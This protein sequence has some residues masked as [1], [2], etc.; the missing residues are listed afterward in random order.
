MTVDTLRKLSKLFALL[1]AAVLAVLVLVSAFVLHN[2]YQSQQRYQ[3]NAEDTSRNLAIS[4]ENFLHSHFQEVDLAMRRAAS[5]FRTLHSERRFD[6]ATFSAFL[7]GL[8]ERLPQA[9]AVRGSDRDGRVI[10]GEKIDLA[11]P[12][13]LSI[14][15]FYQRSKTERELVFGVP[16]KSRISGEWVFP[17]MYALTL[18]DGGFGGTAYVNLNNSRITELFSSLNVGE[19]GVIILIDQQRRVLHRYP[20]S[21]AMQTGSQV[22]LSAETGGILASGQ[23]RA[24][25]SAVSVRD[26]R[27]RVVSVERI[28]GYPIFV[29][30]GLANQDFLTPWRK[31]ARDDAIFLAALYV[32]AGGLLLGVRAALRRQGQALQQ[33]LQKDQAL[34]G[35]LAALTQSEQRWRSLTE[36]LPQMVWTL[37]PQ[38]RFEFLSHHWQDF[39]GIDTVTLLAGA[40]WFDILHADDRGRI[41][42][43]WAA[44][45]AAGGEF[46]CD[47]RLR[48]ADGAWRVFDHHA[49]PQRDP[50]GRLL[51]WVGSSTDITAAREA[52]V[53]LSQAKDAALAAGRAKSEFVANMSHEIR[54]PM[55]AVLGMLQLLQQTAL[56]PRQQD[57]AV[58]AEAAAR[59][60]LSLLNDI[61]DFSKVEAGKLTLDCHPFSVDKLLRDL[62]VILSA[63]IG[64]KDVEVLFQIDPAL[65]KWV[66]GDALRLQ[67]IL[68][69]LSGNAIKFTAHGEV[70]LSVRLLARDEAGLRLAFSIRDTGIGISAEQCERIFEGFSQAEASTARR[71][72]GSGLGLAISQRLVRLMGGELSV[73]STPGLGSVFEF[74]VVLQPAAT[75]AALL[76][77]PTLLQQLDCLVVDDNP[78]ARQVLA[79][80]A[81]SFGWLVETAA[82][83]AAALAALARRGPARPYDVIFVDWRMPQL[84]GWDTAV[85]LRQMLPAGAG[86]LIIMVTAYDRE[87]LAQKQHDQPVQH[88][89]AGATLDGVLVKPVTAS[90]LFDA[91]ADAKLGQRRSAP[92]ATAAAQ[93][94]PSRRRLDGLR[95]L[96]VEDNPANQQVAREL[97]GY[98]GAEVALANCGQ[99]AIDAVRDGAPPDLIL[100]DIQMPDMDGYHATRAIRALLGWRTPPIVAMTAN[101]LASDRAAALAAGMVDHVGKPFDLDQLVA[102]ILAHGPDGAGGGDASGAGGSD[103]AGGPAAPRE[104]AVLNGGAAL[105]RMGGLSQLYLLALRDFAGEAGRIGALLLGAIERQDLAA[106]RPLLHVL[107]GLAGTVGAEQLAGLAAAAETAAVPDGWVALGSV[108]AAIPPALGAIEQLAAELEGAAASGAAG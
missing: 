31:E 35:S 37:T 66:S 64:D 94:A 61:L 104:V 7:R 86:P 48:R 96:L 30:V 42:A 68:L 27:E 107:K 55:N 28:G 15:E 93:P 91:V 49:L 26:G 59:S 34:Q 72:G 101:A 50:A 102:V 36:G 73:D 79:E 9:D 106:A 84:D 16:V 89:A 57:Y 29:V 6:D 98:E 83:G 92:A 19:H 13:N 90:M 8:K 100:M 12:Q 20:E 76:A 69:N 22:A 10:Y 38:R 5:E 45:L 46:R 58:K 103:A 32:L 25:Y 44:A 53:Q 14:R 65:P 70:L 11:N 51:C 52:H 81:Q 41:D 43:A 56:A 17:L 78:S 99:A 2:L 39:T 62:S 47:C 88:E 63:N 3:G 18:P 108:L 1:V 97:L 75:P 54:T 40:A 24:T 71:Y 74:V 85:R 23:R 21:S 87:M 60:L 82:D 105:K 67:Q 95:L 4:L 80:M 33:L 77:D